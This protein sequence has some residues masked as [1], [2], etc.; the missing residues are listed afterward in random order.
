VIGRSVAEE[1]HA[2]QTSRWGRVVDI[3]GSGVESRAMMASM[4][5]T[6]HHR[7]SVVAVP[8][9]P[10]VRSDGKCGV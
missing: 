2:R 6:V 4:G 8:V 3:E 9:N 1:D 10:T 7:G 5:A